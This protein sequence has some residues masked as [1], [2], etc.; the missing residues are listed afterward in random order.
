LAPAPPPPADAIRRGIDFL[1]ERTRHYLDV[2]TTDIVFV[3]RTRGIGVMTGRQAAG[4]AVVGP[5]A[6]ASGIRRDI[7]VQAPYAAYGD[8]PIEMVVERT[9]DLEARIIVRLKELFECYRLIR[10]IL[11]SLPAGDLVA[12]MPRKIKEGETISRIEAPRGELLH[13]IKSNGSDMPERFKVRAPTLC[14]LGSVVALAAGLKLADIPMLL[15]GV[16]P[17]FSCNDRTAILHQ[18][19]S[20]KELWSWERLRRYGIEYYSKRR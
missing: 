1:E 9:G 17:C 13:F 4:L 20:D 8:Y 11:D 7:R 6:R 10:Q 5:T 16:D 14:N 2:V 12:R 15:V 3:Q 19:G 18:K